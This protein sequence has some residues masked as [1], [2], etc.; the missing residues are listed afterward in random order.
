M[1]VGHFEVPVGTIV[2]LQ[3][4]APDKSVFKELTFHQDKQ[5]S[6]FFWRQSVQGMLSRSIPGMWKGTWFSDDKLITTT[7][8]TIEK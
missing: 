4:I 1:F 3:I 5:A 7:L 6:V 2:K 8:I